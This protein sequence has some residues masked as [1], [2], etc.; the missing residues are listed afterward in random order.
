MFD[1]GYL[2]YERFDR[3][4]DECYFFVSRLRKNA[5]VRPIKRFQLPENSLV[6]SDDIV[7]I[8][9]AQNRT[10]NTFRL[11][12]VL[13]SKGNQLNLLTNLFDLSADETAFEYQKVLR[14]ESTKRA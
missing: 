10:E 4:T 9:T 6:Q 5:I 11:L 14:S 8:G 7:V 3:M 2:D 13:D 1:R 12:N